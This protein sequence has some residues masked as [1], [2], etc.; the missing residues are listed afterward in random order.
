MKPMRW[1]D[2]IGINLFWLGL[3]VR[4]T[5]VGSVFTPYLVALFV[6][7]AT[8]NTAL[9]FIST[10]GLV[11]AMLV[12]PAAGLLSDRS[13][14]RFGRR[15]PFIFVG[16]LLDLVFLVAIALSGNFWMLL[17][18][19]LLI[20]FSANIS[21]GPLQGLIPDLVPE[22]QRGRSSA[23]KAAFELIPIILVGLTIAQLV[24]K[25]QLGG[26][27]SP[28]ARRCWRPCC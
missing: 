1:Y 5:A 6:P 9:G 16:T 14:S 26:Q 4:N 7:E 11:I 12:Q 2:H 21:H 24:G 19:T 18:A 25:G 20:Q 3:N 23:V 28:P 17:V 13:T 10:A 15:R 22:N 27:S 8:R